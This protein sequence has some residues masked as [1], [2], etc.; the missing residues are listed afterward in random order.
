M[1]TKERKKSI[2]EAAERCA[3]NQRK[4]A[5]FTRA[6]IAKEAHCS[7]GLVSRYLG[8]MVTIRRTVMKRTSR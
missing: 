4:G 5:S 6:A 2:L 7:T 8:D 3:Y 1:T